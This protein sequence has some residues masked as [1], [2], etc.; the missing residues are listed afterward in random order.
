LLV[1]ATRDQR[2]ADVYADGYNHPDRFWALASS[3]ERTAAFLN[4]FG[5]GGAASAIG[6]S[7][8]HS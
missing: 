5:A 7:A 2:V 4:E 6:I 1:A 3:A 8:A